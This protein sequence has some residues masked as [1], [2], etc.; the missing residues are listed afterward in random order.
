MGYLR[1]CG[2]AMTASGA[3]SHSAPTARLALEHPL[4][5][6]LSAVAVNTQP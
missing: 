6:Y 1:N 5:S 3:R 4:N 2:G